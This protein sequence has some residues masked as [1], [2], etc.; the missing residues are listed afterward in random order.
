MSGR[1]NVNAM[2]NIL[3]QLT[4]TGLLS[5]LGLCSAQAQQAGVAEHRYRFAFQGEMSTYTEKVLL[6][7]LLN[8]DL[9]MKVAV[10]RVDHQ[11]K[12]LAYVPVDPQA[13]VTLASQYGVA[14]VP[15]RTV[16]DHDGTY[17]THD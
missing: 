5:C 4:L 7:S 2:R 10:D 11:M 3:L 9:N 8:L 17:S 16:T 1:Q 15:R 12:V 14:L 13:I 6:E